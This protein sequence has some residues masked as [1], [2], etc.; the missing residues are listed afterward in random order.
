MRS[1]SL[2]MFFVLLLVPFVCLISCGGG[3]GGDGDG[4]GDGDSNI[5][6]FGEWS[7]ATEEGYPISFQVSDNQVTELEIKFGATSYTH[8]QSAPIDDNR[9]FSYTSVVPISGTFEDGGHCSG[10]WGDGGTWEAEP[11]NNS[12]QANVTCTAGCNQMSWGIADEVGTR[13][14]EKQCSR[15]YSGNSYADNCTG[16]VS[17]EGSGNSYEFSVEYDWVNCSIDVSVEGVGTCNDS[18]R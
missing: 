18:A 2:K 9:S 17:Y 11:V 15:T 4:D 6:I 13:T 7:G 1:S 8:V 14:I 12:I 10:V 5:I 3:G 16:T